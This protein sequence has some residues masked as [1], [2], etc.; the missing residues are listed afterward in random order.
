M[1]MKEVLFKYCGLPEAVQGLSVQQDI[2]FY[3][4]AEHA[5]AVDR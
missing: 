3:Q 1:T 2:S 4:E 5:N